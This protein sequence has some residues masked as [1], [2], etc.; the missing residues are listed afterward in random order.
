MMLRVYLEHEQLKTLDRDVTGRG[1]QPD[2]V[3]FVST[4][5]TS[6][7][8]HQYRGE[9][10]RLR[11]QSLWR[12]VQGYG[13]KLGVPA[14]ELHPHAFRH[15]FGTEMAEG[16]VPLLMQQDLMG[17]SDPK[18]T[19][20]YTHLAMRRKVAAMDQAGPLAKIKTPMSAL[21]ARL[22]STPPKGPPAGQSGGH[23]A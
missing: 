12:I 4:R 14:A 9:A 11:R 1:G 16:D 21:L 6:V 20:I 15:L 2:R 5:N 18:S 7:Q 3:L 10:T 22:P 23:N 8:A 13:R 17:H 19:A